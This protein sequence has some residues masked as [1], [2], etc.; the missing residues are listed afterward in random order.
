MGY[1]IACPTPSHT[2]KISGG[3]LIETK[4]DQESRSNS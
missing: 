3:A 1:L 4:T 2:F